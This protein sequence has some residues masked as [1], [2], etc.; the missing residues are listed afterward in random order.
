V[1]TFISSLREERGLILKY[2]LENHEIETN[3]KNKK[4]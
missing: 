2:F 1:A 3:F 4:Y